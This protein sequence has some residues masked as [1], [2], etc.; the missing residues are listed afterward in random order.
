MNKASSTKRWKV[1]V[2]NYLAIFF[3]DWDA[4]FGFERGSNI[5]VKMNAEKHVLMLNR[6]NVCNKFANVFA[7]PNV[8]E[9]VLILR[10]ENVC[11]ELAN[12]YIVTERKAERCAQE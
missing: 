6:E 12:C 5:F 3:R 7:K 2:Q 9:L 1:V 11:K 10:R 8:K 4:D